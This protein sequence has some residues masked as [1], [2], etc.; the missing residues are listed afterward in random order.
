MG[1]MYVYEAS[2]PGLRD[3]ASMSLM[4]ACFATTLSLNLLLTLMIVI[5]LILHSR[6]I[7][8]ALGSLA[9]PGASGLYEAI[10]TV[11]VES[12]AV[13]TVSFLLVVV[14][15]GVNNSIENTFLLVLPNIQVRGVFVFPD[16]RNLNTLWRRIGYR[17]VPDHPTSRQ[18]ESIDER[19]YGLRDHRF[20]SFQEESWDVDGWRWVPF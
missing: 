15:W 2:Q 9:G 17:P 10:V 4:L 7:R 18:A 12:S 13:Y 6:S 3:P 16:L 19:N 5:R 1:I 20:G 14:S 11:L 8:K